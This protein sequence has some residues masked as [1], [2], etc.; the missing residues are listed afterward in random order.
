MSKTAIAG[1]LL[2]PIFVILQS[3]Q[4]VDALEQVEPTEIK[5]AYTEPI[6]IATFKA[7]ALAQ[8]PADQTKPEEIQ[9]IVTENDSLSKIASAHNTTWK[10]IY[11]KNVSIV[12]PDV[13]IPGTIITI[14]KADE[15]L[16]E[17]SLP[18]PLVSVPSQ[19]ANKAVVSN[20]TARSARSS[21]VSSRSQSGSTAGNRYVPG[22][23][24]WYVKNKRPSLPNNLGN[25]DT[26][27]TRAAAQG[28][29]TG[30][31]PRA[32]SVGQ[33]GMHV[34]YVE[35]VNEDGSVN[36]SEMNHKGLYVITYRTLPAS[37]FTY[38]N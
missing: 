17:R 19:T 18:E 36:I 1:L 8:E 35:S 3:N 24:T 22:Y 14:P 25:A 34:V 21:S 16:A 12:Y 11:D 31:T 5:I 33:R 27:V 37:Y 13:I 6:A 23:C 2:L 38:I 30:S 10:R 7:P 4:K 9:Y 28:M 26:W 20:A 32:G 15:V 29:A